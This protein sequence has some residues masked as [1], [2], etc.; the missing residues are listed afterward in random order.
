MTATALPTLLAALVL[1]SAT[2]AAGPASAGGRHSHRTP[3]ARARVVHVHDHACG[4]AW[5]GEHAASYSYSHSHQTSHRVVTTR[6]SVR[7]GWVWVEDAW[8]GGTWVVAG[9]IPAAP[10][11]S[12]VLWTP[13]YWSVDGDWVDGRFTVVVR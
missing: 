2:F 11:P 9:W 3:L 8:F 13:G 12:G 7:S 1:A 10:A 5:R 6:T 4:H